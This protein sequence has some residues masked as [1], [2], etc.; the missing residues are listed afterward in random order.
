MD[1]RQDSPVVSNREQSLK[2]LNQSGSPV[3]TLLFPDLKP[4]GTILFSVRITPKPVG[5]KG[6]LRHSPHRTHLLP[7]CPMLLKV[8]SPPPTNRTLNPKVRTRL[9][10]QAGRGTTRPPV[11]TRVAPC[12]LHV[13]SEQTRATRHSLPESVTG[14]T[15]GGQQQHP[16]P[17][18]GLCTAGH[19]SWASRAF[20]VL[21]TSP[22]D[23][24]GG[25]RAR[26]A[27]GARPSAN[28]RVS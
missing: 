23:Q 15:A 5:P 17:P 26:R 12:R 1:T 3:F 2:S 14:A 10:A 16:T 21:H 13:S 18:R 6:K 24:L 25:G 8:P 22:L 27:L 19:C 28:Y 20:P 11:L 7:A 9:P 4:L